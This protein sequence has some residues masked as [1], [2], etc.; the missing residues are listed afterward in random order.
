MHSNMNINLM[1]APR[2]GVPQN[3]G[4]EQLR[5]MHNHGLMR[6]PNPCER[7]PVM[8]EVDDLVHRNRARR[9]S[10]IELKQLY[11]ARGHMPQIVFKDSSQQAQGDIIRRIQELDAELQMKVASICDRLRESNAQPPSALVSFCRQMRNSCK[12]HFRLGVIKDIIPQ[13]FFYFTYSLAVTYYVHLQEDWK[14]RWS[15]AKEDNLYYPAVVLAFL[16]CF[17]ASGCMER[18]KEGMRTSF[19]M[20]KCLRDMV[21]EVITHLKEE[22]LTEVDPSNTQ[23]YLNSRALKKRYFK[24]EFRRLTCLLFTCAARDLND[25]ALGEDGVELDEEDADRIRCSVTEVEHAAVMVTHSAYG[26]AFRVYIAA[27][28]LLKLLRGVAMDGLFT[29]DDVYLN[30]ESKISQFRAAWL[31]ARQVAYSSMPDSVI[32]ILWLL[33]TVMNLFMPWQW[34]TVTKWYTWFPGLLLTISSC[35]ILEIANSMENP[36]GFDED[37]I[38]ISETSQQLDEEICLILTYAILNEVGGEN[39]YRQMMDEDMI[40][41]S[42]HAPEHAGIS[43]YGGNMVMNVAHG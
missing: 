35:G 18:Y 37:D 38:Q 10:K 22:P 39:L 33:T 40:F 4:Y 12:R 31:D 29:D 30:A 26:H 2:S 11:N 9:L 23:E 8:V 1:T 13:I 32:H 25:S 6:A 20:Q 17:R 14:V 42:G 7:N 16:L 36:F 15:L 19:E 3:S 24:H 21:Y 27:S 43:G 34:V 28:W 41:L 5:E